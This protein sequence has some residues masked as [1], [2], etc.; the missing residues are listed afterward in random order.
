M[1]YGSRN[2]SDKKCFTTKLRFNLGS[3]FKHECSIKFKLD[4]N[5]FLP[6][7]LSILYL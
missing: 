6:G 1:V 5:K 7:F 3:P 4:I 2:Y